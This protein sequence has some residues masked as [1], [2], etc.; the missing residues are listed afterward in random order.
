MELTG[1]AKLLRIFC[2]EGDV[3][4]H[5]ALHESIV[6]EART[7]GLAGTTV[8]RGIMSFGANSRIRSSKVLDLSSD[9]PIVIEIVDAETKIDAFL[10]QLQ[11]IFEE[12]GCGGL[13]TLEKVQI[14][15]YVHKKK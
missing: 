5:M 12:S 2:G 8:W 11:A 9:L 3:H 1:Q 10:P 13:V 6:K 15:R 4:R 14:M 7:A